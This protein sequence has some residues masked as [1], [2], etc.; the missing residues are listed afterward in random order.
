VM[1]Q[2]IRS[3][4]TKRLLEKIGMLADPG[5]QDEIVSRLLEHL[6]IQFEADELDG[7]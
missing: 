4:S 1:P 2:Q 6:D 5:Y 7:G 3:I